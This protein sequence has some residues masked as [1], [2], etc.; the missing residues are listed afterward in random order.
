M[1]P[2]IGPGSFPAKQ[3]GNA[4]RA[5]ALNDELRALHQE[6]H[7]LRDLI[8]ADADQVLH[9]VLDQLQRQFAGTLDGDAVGDRADGVDGDR[10]TGLDRG[11]ERSAGLNL[12]ADDLHLGA[13]GPDRH[14]DPADQTSAPD[15]HHNACEVGH[16]TQK[17]EP[18]ATLARDHIDIVE[19]MDELHP[20]L[21]RTLL[22]RGDRL[23]HRASCHM[24]RGA[25]RLHGVGLGDRRLFGHEH[26]AR[27]T[28]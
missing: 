27:H 9:P 7:R 21:R 24:Q 18:H 25:E 20:G 15:R 6:H 19:W 1:E 26:L 10:V 5:G 4:H 12:N 8:L 2:S 16:L 14:R 13:L 28:A 17:L 11:D 22:G 3:G 23:V